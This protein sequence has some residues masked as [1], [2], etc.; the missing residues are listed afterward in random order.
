MSTGIISPGS[1]LEAWSGVKLICISSSRKYDDESK[2][3]QYFSNV[4]YNST[5]QN[6]FTEVMKVTSDTELWDANLA[7]YSQPAT[8]DFVFGLWV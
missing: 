1:H 7:W 4:K 2:F 3:L 8:I 5:D 6:A